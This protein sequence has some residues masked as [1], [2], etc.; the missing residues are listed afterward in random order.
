MNQFLHKNTTNKMESYQN[1]TLS[2]KPDVVIDIPDEDDDE[3]DDNCCCS[4]FMKCLTNWFAP[5]PY[6]SLC[7]CCGTRC[8]EA[9]NPWQ[10]ACIVRLRFL[11]FWLGCM[12]FILMPMLYQIAI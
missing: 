9:T 11:G 10:H 8:C 6:A 2:E 5:L 7:V 12:C 3:D 1:E 4:C